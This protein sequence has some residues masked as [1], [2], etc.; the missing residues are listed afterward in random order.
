MYLRPRGP[1]L[2]VDPIQSGRGGGTHRVG[3]RKAFGQG[4]RIVGG[5]LGSIKVTQYTV[6]LRKPKPSFK[7]VL[8]IQQSRRQA[9]NHGADE[10]AAFLD[11]HVLS[12]LDI[13]RTGATRVPRVRK[14]I[15]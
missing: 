2:F 7:I 14:E 1:N 13:G 9:V 5:V 15:S 11:R 10:S 6:R 12:G 4:A 3:F 8:V